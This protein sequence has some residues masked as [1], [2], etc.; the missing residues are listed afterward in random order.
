M[1]IRQ[2]NNHLK[3]TILIKSCSKFEVELFLIYEIKSVYL[4]YLHL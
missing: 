1:I 2:I 3:I 4:L